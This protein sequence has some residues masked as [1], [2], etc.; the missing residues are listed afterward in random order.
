MET[1]LNLKTNTYKYIV[2]LTT[3]LVNNKIYIGVHKTKDPSVFDGYLGC[4]VLIN[5]PSSYMKPETPFQYAVKKYGVK[6]FKRVTIKEF[7]SLLDALDLERFLVC[8]EFLKRGDTYNS[9]LGGGPGFRLNIVNQF[10]LSGNF[11]KSWNNLLEASDFYQVPHTAVL[12]AIKYKSSCKKYYW[13]YKDK[14]NIEE[15]TKPKE[16]E[17]CYLYDSKTLKYIKEFNSVPEVS[18]YLNVTMSSVQQSIL[19]KYK[20]KNYYIS[21]TLYDEFPIQSKVKIS[22]NTLYI[23]DLDGNFITELDSDIKIKEFFNIKNFTPIS[24][25]LRKHSPFKTYQISLEKVSKMDKVNDKRNYS[26]RVGR[27]SKTGELLEEFDSTSQAIEKYN[28]SVQRCL[29][30]Q[31]QFCKGFVFRYI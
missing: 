4:G 28:T 7:D 22:G 18:K 25:A 8:P 30:G 26:K 6:N 5:S 20:L 15:F 19:G 12:N 17:K 27:F 10:D 23:Y 13:S 1:N 3:N 21:R 31:Q 11:V 16:I 29:R 2:Y 24:K 9:C 14:I